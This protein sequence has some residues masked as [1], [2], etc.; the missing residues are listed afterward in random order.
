MIAFIISINGYWSV[1][2]IKLSIFN[3]ERLIDNDFISIRYRENHT[4]CTGPANLVRYGI[5]Y[6]V[7]RECIG[8]EDAG[9]APA[10]ERVDLH[11][12]S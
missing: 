1:T 12:G 4:Q 6:S 11:L 3:L 5:L 9:C 7:S 8:L 10:M 2:A